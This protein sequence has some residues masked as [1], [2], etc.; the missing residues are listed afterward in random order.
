MSQSVILDTGPWIA[1]LN[2][3]DTHHRWARE[4]WERISA[5]LHVCEPVVTETCYLAQRLGSGAQEAV[6]EFFQRGLIDLSFRLADEGADVTRL[7]KKYRD[8]PM[9][10]ADGCIVRMAEQRAR[11][12]VFTLDSDFSI[13]RMNG[14]RRIPTLTPQR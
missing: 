3:R 5:P 9:S 6:L 8:V 1:L 12:L 11:S 4:T 13:Y 14:R 7:L 10:L 2:P